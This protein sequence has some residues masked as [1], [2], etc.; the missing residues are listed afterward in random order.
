MQTLKR[1]VSAETFPRRRIAFSGATAAA[2][3]VYNGRRLYNFASNDYLAFAQ[4]PELVAA[5]ER[6]ARRSGVASSGSVYMCGYSE[7]HRELES[8]LAAVTGRE[9]AI[10]FSSGYLA[11]LGAVTAL[12]GRDDFICAD[13]YIHASLV[14]AIRLSGP[15]CPPYTPGCRRP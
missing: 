11:N 3:V 14:D 15:L 4:R 9:R 7:L 10:V 2:E 1:P 6:E 12:C 13:R 8:E 5:M